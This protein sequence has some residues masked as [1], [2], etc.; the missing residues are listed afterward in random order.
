MRRTMRHA[1]VCL[2]ALAAST[3]PAGQGV[4]NGRRLSVGPG[5][6]LV[7]TDPDLDRVVLFDV[8]G[9]R[10]RRLVAFGERGPKPGQLE[11]PHG[12]AITA[13]GNLLVADTFNHRVQAF[14]LTGALAGWPGR[15]LRTFGGLGDGPGALNTPQAGLAVSPIEDE[16]GRVFVPDSRNHRVVVYDVGGLPTGMVVGG[17][18]GDEP[19]RLDT[20]VGLAFDPSGRRIYVAE[21]GNR[22]VSA[23][24]ADTGAFLFAF[25]RETLAAPAGIAAD[26]KGDLLVT[27]LVTRKVH[28]FRPEPGASPGSARPVASWGRAGSGPGEWSYPQSVAVDAKDRVYVADLASGRCQ[29]FTSDGAYVAAF[30]DDVT[31][32]YPPESPPSHGDV[33]TPTRSTCSN[34]GRYRVS[35]RAP[36]PWPLN[37]LFGLEVSVEEGCDPPRRPTAARLRVDAAMPEHRHGMNTDAVVTP[38]GSGRFGAEGLLLH[39]PGRWEMYFDVTDRG[40]TERAQ[41]DFILE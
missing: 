25:G 32:G 35:V 29:M 11:S 38:R 21:A 39:M 22:R 6:L 26:S 5:H 28:R 24:S 23:F 30:G 33:G 18:R 27:D 20:P 37:D 3:A 15:L 41:L 40:V 34:G 4:T 2:M 17:G 12:A 19:G 31:L 16:Q 9:D 8:R 36:E 13:R 7:M 14:D 1:T 10:P